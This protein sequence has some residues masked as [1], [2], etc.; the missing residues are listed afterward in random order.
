MGAY[1]EGM[2]TPVCVLLCITAVG[3]G[4]ET[5]AGGE[6]DGSTATPPD[7]SPPDGSAPDGSAPD[8]TPGCPKPVDCSDASGGR[9][10][11]PPPV[12]EPWECVPFIDHYSYTDCGNGYVII[13]KVMESNGHTR[14]YRDGKLFAVF[15]GYLQQFKCV[16]GPA[17]FVRPECRGGT[18]INLCPRDAA[19][20]R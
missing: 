8:A 20:S 15:A 10:D 19:A 5:A 17:D 16:E 3:C 1:V 12:A 11:L 18:S 9:C 7:G 4:P 6:Q 14:Y 13:S 2:R